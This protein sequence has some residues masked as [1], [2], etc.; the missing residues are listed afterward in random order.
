MSRVFWW[1]DLDASPTRKRWMRLGSSSKI[2]LTTL[3]GSSSSVTA[4]AAT[5]SEPGAG[6]KREER[7]ESK[8]QRV[9]RQDS[10][11]NV[12]VEKER[13]EVKK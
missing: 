3:W 9:K 1:R 13:K 2:V 12:I 8:S 10:R 5:D 6:V 4:M 7:E 11:K